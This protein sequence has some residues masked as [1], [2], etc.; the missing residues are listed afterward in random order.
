MDDAP[1]ALLNR[2]RLKSADACRQLV[3]RVDVEMAT[4]GFAEYNDDLKSHM[5]DEPQT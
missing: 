2:T 5:L 1:L 4:I 3:S